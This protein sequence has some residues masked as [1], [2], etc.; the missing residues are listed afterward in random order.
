MSFLSKLFGIRS[1]TEKKEDAFIN[2]MKVAQEDATVRQTLLSILVLESTLRK[3]ALESLT[4]KIQMQG[5][6]S[7][8]VDALQVFQDDDASKKALL[9][10]KQD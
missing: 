7:E 8:F 4:V 2:L 9:L 1:Q 6:P 3:F 5:A 10:L